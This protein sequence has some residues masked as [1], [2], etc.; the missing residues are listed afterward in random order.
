MRVGTVGTG[1]IVDNFIDA[2]SKTEG[3]Q[4]AAVYSRDE[5]KAAA[6]AAKHSVSRHY[7]DRAE[8]LA[9][10][11]LDFIY[12]ASPNSLH[13]SWV[14]DALFAG[15]N[16]IC[17]KPSVSNRVELEQL[18]RIAKENGLFLFEAITVPHLPNYALIKEQLPKLGKLKMVQL[19]FSQYSSKYNAYLQG[20]NP[21][22]FNPE[23]SGGALMDLN[24]YNLWFCYGLFGAPK[25]IKYFPNLAPNGIDTS[26][27][28]VLKYDGFMCSAVACKDSKSKNSTQIQG[29]KGYILVPNESSRCTDFMV[30]VGDEQSSFNVQQEDNS[31]C[32]ELADFAGIF[33]RGDYGRRDELLEHSLEVAGLIE[34][35]RK[36]A[37]IAFAADMGE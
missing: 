35:A 21:N 28:L 19:N 27:V 8:F 3:V 9:D 31:L 4:I 34:K 18:A 13:F 2:A 1:L 16:V 26:G 20:K 10:K 22:V 17:E 5:E 29:E 11:D 6:F 24:C 23:F 33:A 32:Y 25:D 7:C 36:G 15:R 37:G 14:R 12:V 30:F